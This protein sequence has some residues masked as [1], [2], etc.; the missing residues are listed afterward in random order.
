M[1][2]ALALSFKRRTMDTDKLFVV[3]GQDDLPILT[4]LCFLGVDIGYVWLVSCHS[5]TLAVLFY[6][7]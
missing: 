7:T 5:L 2:P 1:H 6:R 4:N 3:V